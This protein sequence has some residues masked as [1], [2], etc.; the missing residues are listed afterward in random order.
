MTRQ[1]YAIFQELTWLL[2]DFATDAYPDRKKPERVEKV[3]DMAES[4]ILQ[5]EWKKEERLK[6]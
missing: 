2:H 3:L 6:H 1:E 4:I 5:R